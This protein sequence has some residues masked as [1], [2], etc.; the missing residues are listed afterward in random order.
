MSQHDDYKYS[1]T[2]QS[3]DLPLV[4]SLRGLAWYCQ[5]TGNR[6][7]AWGGT[8]RPDWEKNGHHITF[9]FNCTR[10]RDNFLNE[11]R[12]LFSTGWSKA[13]QSESDPAKRQSPN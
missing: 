2:V 3:D 11:A 13:S 5:E 7:I 6:Q 9:H 12:R 1:V 8:K 10:Y 4:S